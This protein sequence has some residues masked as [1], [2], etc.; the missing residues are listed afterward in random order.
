[1]CVSQQGGSEMHTEG[2]GAE[3]QVKFFFLLKNLV[4]VVVI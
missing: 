2:D 4:K 3:W 1:M